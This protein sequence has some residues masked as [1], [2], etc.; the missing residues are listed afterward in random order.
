MSGQHSL[1]FHIEVS[2]VTR[3]LHFTAQ[4]FSLE[5][6]NLQREIKKVNS[7]KIDLSLD[8]VSK[9]DENHSAPVDL[10][11]A[12]RS[13]CLAPGKASG[14][15]GGRPLQLQAATTTTVAATTSDP[16]RQ[17]PLRP[18]PRRRTRMSLPLDSRAARM[19]VLIS[20]R[21]SKHQRN[22]QLR[23]CWRRTFRI[24]RWHRKTRNQTH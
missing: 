13:W 9:T 20:S 19:S 12:W 14:T 2:L 3:I 1:S 22:Y 4:L 7:T 15:G 24:R 18:W 6:P 16:A 5:L 10:I 21:Q 8:T 17:G 23:A 11:S